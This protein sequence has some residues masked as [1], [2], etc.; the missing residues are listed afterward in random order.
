LDGD[1]ELLTV[2][3]STG[4]SPLEFSRLE[5]K[6]ALIPATIKT[7]HVSANAISLYLLQFTP[8]IR[9]LAAWNKR[10]SK[11]GTHQI[12]RQRKAVNWRYAKKF[13]LWPFILLAF[14]ER[15]PR[16]EKMGNSCPL[17]TRFIHRILRNEERDYM[18]SS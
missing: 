18:A 6:L 11:N 7:K 3:I 9:S 16:L 5:H 4:N 2:C 10:S 12:A 17:S 8:L 15:E 13:T 14:I 1:I